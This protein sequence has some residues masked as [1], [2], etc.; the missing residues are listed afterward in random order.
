MTSGPNALTL[1]TV[2]EKSGADLANLS[3]W[4]CTPAPVKVLFTAAAMP[5]PYSV[6]SLITKA[7]LGLLALIRKLAAAGPCWSSLAT[8]RCQYFQPFWA[9]PGLVA[10]GDTL[11]IWAPSSCAPIAL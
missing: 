2:E 9:R 8:T 10:D 11:G 6:S 5:T 7:F 1:D 4:V 3:V